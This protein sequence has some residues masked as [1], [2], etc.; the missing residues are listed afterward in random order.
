MS[1]HCGVCQAFFFSFA[2]HFN[3]YIAVIDSALGFQSL[4]AREAIVAPGTSMP[5]GLPKCLAGCEWLSFGDKPG[6]QL[7]PDLKMGS[8]AQSGIQ[9]LRGRETL[10]LLHMSTSIW[11]S[12]ASKWSQEM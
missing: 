1:I 11:G 10:Q 12:A 7:L 6:V 3:V 2:T 8:P 9:L 4:L 5:S